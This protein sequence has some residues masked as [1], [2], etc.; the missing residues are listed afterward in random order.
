MRQN[1][2]KNIVSYKCVKCGKTSNIEWEVEFIKEI[3]TENEKGLANLDKVPIQSK[4]VA[5]TQSNLDM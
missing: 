5:E 1:L 3:A 4:V 2:H